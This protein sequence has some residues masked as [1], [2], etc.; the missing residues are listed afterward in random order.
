MKMAQILLVHLVNFF[1]A[2]KD[3]ELNFVLNLRGIE[4]SK[5]EV[6]TGLSG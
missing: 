4:P 5:S 6:P 2:F 1:G 3:K